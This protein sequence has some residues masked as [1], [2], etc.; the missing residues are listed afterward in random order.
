MNTILSSSM[1]FSFVH[2]M[3]LF[4]YHILYPAA[5]SPPEMFQQTINAT[6][7]LLQSE[8]EG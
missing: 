2:N 1:T 8:K 4:Y 7:P 6:E 5:T 3:Y